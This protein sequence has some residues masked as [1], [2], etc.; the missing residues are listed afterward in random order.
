[1]FGRRQG[2]RKPVCKH[3]IGW[4]VFESNRFLLNTLPGEVIFRANMEGSKLQVVPENYAQPYEVGLATKLSTLS[5][6]PRKIM[7]RIGFPS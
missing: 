4:Q 1:M 2:L 5:S 6:R 7:T 3:L